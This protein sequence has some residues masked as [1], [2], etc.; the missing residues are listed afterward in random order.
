[1]TLGSLHSP[2]PRTQEKR[3]IR[4]TVSGPPRTKKNSRVHTRSGVPLPS[5]A[6]REWTA[7]AQL[8]VDGCDLVYAP[9]GPLLHA[10]R[11]V[12]R[13][14]VPLCDPMNCRAIFY[15]DALRGDAVGFYQGLADLLEARG[16]IT[17]DRH[18]VS[19]DGSRLEKDS[20][21]PRVELW[22]EPAA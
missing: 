5:K 20:Q 10:G 17:D 13:A 6:W 9:H 7:M 3:V 22:L 12:F 21:N 8:S 11:G 16:I 1:M 2:E 18:L 19:W 4:V 14:W 15:R